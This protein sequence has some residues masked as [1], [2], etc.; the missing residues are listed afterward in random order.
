M[1]YIN[2]FTEIISKIVNNLHRVSKFY[3]KI[4]HV[5]RLLKKN[6]NLNKSNLLYCIFIFAVLCL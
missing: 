5:L 1:Y 6:V 2:N 3:Q 4:R